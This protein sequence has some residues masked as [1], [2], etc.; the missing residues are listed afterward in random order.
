MKEKIIELLKNKVMTIMELADKLNQNSGSEYTNLVKM[1]N[2]LID[3]NECFESGGQIYLTKNF[4]VCTVKRMDGSFYD[5][6]EGKEIN[7][8]SN[9]NLSDGD[10][11]IYLEKKRFGECVKVLKR[12][13]IYVLGTMMKRRNGFYFFSDEYRFQDYKV[14][15]QKEFDL[16]DNLR[17]RTYISNYEK[18]ELKI[19]ALIGLAGSEG[20]LIKTIL[21]MNNAPKDF[22]KKVIK[23]AESI[24]HTISFNNRKDLTSLPFITIDGVD[25]K[26]FD[27]AIC[28]IEK[29]DGYDLYVSIADVSRYVLEDSYLDQEAK[30]RGTSIY[31]PGKVIP[32]LPEVLC[33]DLCSL[34]EGVNRYTLTCQM[35]VGYDGVVESYDIY[36]SV[37]CS[38]HR[39]S[40]PNVNK[41]LEHDKELLEKYDDIIQMIYTAYQ[42]SRIV[43]KARKDKGGIEF[44]SNEPIIIEE[45]GKVVDIKLRE[46]G[47]AELLIEDFMILANETVA[48]HMYYLGYPLMYRNHDN[49]KTDKLERFINVVEELGYTFKGNK[50]ELKSS[51][52]Q[53][54]LS[55]FENKEEYAI[56]SDLLLQSMAKALYEN[57]CIGHF[58]LGLDYYCHFTSPIR[59][60]PDLMVHR[61]LKKYVFNSNNFDDIDQDINMI[62]E[63][64]V[65]CNETEKRA[66]QIERNVTDLKRCEYMADKINQVFDGIICSVLKFGFYV[67]LPNTVEGLVHVNSLDGFFEFDGECLTNDIITYKVGQKVKVRL[68]SVDLDKRNID[69]KVI[70]KRGVIR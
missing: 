35:K 64:A 14:V 48:T 5:L 44:D 60:Y 37:I 2:E 13:N 10:E 46:Q 15:N 26:D 57:N 12:K 50:Y 70:S 69:F 47:K 36:P 42:L 30:N 4:K 7:N 27:D 58:G 61:M 54:C 51:A 62:G 22:N 53:K 39:M 38:K 55:S 11:I 56:V 43:D 31:Y 25:A 8:A 33:N 6:N 65:K 45:D 19:D 41:I 40:Y 17:V 3:S 49:P 59:R 63:I 34:K 68:I 32:M 16:K 9:F 24:D 67:Q 23:E 28:V 18:K 1:I 21:L 66:T 20:V 52:L 29:E